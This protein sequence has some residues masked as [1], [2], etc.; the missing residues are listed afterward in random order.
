M[1]LVPTIFTVALVVLTIVLTIV[2]FQMVLVLLELKKTLRK[3]NE[4]LETADKK[5]EAI[6]APLQKMAGVATG[7][8]TGIKVL[9][10]F[11]GWLQRDKSQTKH[12]GK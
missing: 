5:I 6:V 9:E 10:A 1:E 4:A 3:V 11:V 7:L 2:G 12:D 8:G